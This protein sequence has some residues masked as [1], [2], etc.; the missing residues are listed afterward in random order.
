MGATLPSF[1][2]REVIIL[3]PVCEMI[4]TILPLGVY[5]N[6][7]FDEK[8]GFESQVLRKHFNLMEASMSDLYDSYKDAVKVFPELQSDFDR[9][10]ATDTESPPQV[11]IQD[12]SSQA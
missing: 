11:H 4:P 1:P 2:A 9:L 10:L 8:E 6:S 5:H 7:S 12:N 3:C